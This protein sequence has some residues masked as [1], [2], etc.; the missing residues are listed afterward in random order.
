VSSTYEE[1]GG[2]PSAVA[3]TDENGNLA[4]DFQNLKLKFSDLTADDKE[5]IRGPQGVSAV[6]DPE[7]GNILSTLHN[8]TG[9][10]DANA[11]TQKAVT[12]AIFDSVTLKAK[13]L[14]IYDE[15]LNPD[16]EITKANYNI[17]R[18]TGK[19]NTN[20]G[21]KHGILPVRP[22][23]KY[24]F[25][26]LVDP[27][28]TDEFSDYCCYAFATSATF[29]SGK[30]V[31]IV[32]GTSI[33]T[34]DPS[35]YK[36]ITIPEGCSHLLLSN[37]AAATQGGIAFVIKWEIWRTH[38]DEDLDKLEQKFDENLDEVEQRVDEEID[39]ITQ[40]IEDIVN[41][42]YYDFD[43]TEIAKFPL[44]AY[45]QESGTFGGANDKFA[46]YHFSK[47]VSVTMRGKHIR[48]T[49]QEGKNI[50]L[51][52]FKTNEPKAKKTRIYSEI[53]RNYFGEVDEVVDVIVP[54]DVEY[55]TF[56][57][58]RSYEDVRPVRIEVYEKSSLEDLRKFVE[59]I[60][61]RAV[62]NEETIKA[63]IRQALWVADDME[64]KPSPLAL[65]HYSDIHG[66][67]EAA[68]KIL[69]YIE[70]LNAYTDDVL[71]TGDSAD[72]LSN[73]GNGRDWWVNQSGLAEKSLFVL[74]NHD[75]ATEDA[76]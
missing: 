35:K 71:C 53:L 49:P 5:A 66:T 56:Q 9:Q 33:G 3:S 1:N 41:M 34:V 7:T 58:I 21:K 15:T 70:S 64:G 20:N 4:F 76:T 69:Q 57:Q 37:D 26:S 62:N 14:S 32:E 46:A 54:E 48:L 19:F 73:K 18:S 23:E 45:A 55:V 28:N 24:I 25:R 72:Y 29:G 38:D 47:D 74:G 51:F 50:R 11:M 2:S 75:G 52:F 13:Q 17:V 22:G 8:T 68:Q 43:E 67:D 60:A 12:D 6:F 59:S 42:R 61:E 31:P 44:G 36:I 27:E 10:D 65:L 40:Q 30:S 39:D 16:G 63:I